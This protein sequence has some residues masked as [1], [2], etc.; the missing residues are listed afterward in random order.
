MSN[1]HPAATCLLLGVVLS[2]LGGLLYGALA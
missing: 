2:T 1:L